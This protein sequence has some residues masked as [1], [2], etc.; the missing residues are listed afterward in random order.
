MQVIERRGQGQANVQAFLERQ[1]AA[2]L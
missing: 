1:A 2:A